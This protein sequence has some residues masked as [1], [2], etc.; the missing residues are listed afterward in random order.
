MVT[1]SRQE[2]P[3]PRLFVVAH[4][5]VLTAGVVIAAAPAEPPM[6]TSRGPP[7]QV[8]AVRTARD[9]GPWGVPLRTSVISPG[10]AG[11]V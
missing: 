8:R 1:V 6:I 2:T 7:G 11:T 4:Q 3:A 5:V 10:L 9:V